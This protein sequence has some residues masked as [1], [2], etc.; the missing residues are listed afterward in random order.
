MSQ[1]LQHICRMKIV[2]KSCKSFLIDDKCVSVN[3]NVFLK[4]FIRVSS[5]V[6]IIFI[7]IATKDAILL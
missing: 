5:K 4:M 2:Q 1:Q 6:G 7:M 3:A